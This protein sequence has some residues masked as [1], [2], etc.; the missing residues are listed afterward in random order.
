M[1]HVP[2]SHLSPITPLTPEQEAALKEQVAKEGYVERV[3][4]GIDACANVVTGGLPDETISSRAARDA[5]EGKKFGTLVSKVLNVCQRNH[6]AQAQAG[7]LERAE[8]A[9]HAELSDGVLPTE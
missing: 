6:G 3:L 1:G 7:D 8:A 5:R 4:V 2:D 9:E